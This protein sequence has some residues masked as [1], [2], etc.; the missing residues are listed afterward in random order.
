[1][2]ALG[3]GEGGDDAGEIE[4]DDGAVL[5]RL[6]LVAPEALELVVLLDGG[7]EGLVA[8]GEA[9]VLEGLIVDGEEADGGAVLG[10]ML[11]MVARSA[12]GSSSRPGP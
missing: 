11:A 4:L 1:L 7:D 5:D 9:E 10:A 6:G 12:R 2:G 3:A 8:A